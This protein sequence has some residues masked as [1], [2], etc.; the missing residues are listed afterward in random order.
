MNK[1]NII[2]NYVLKYSCRI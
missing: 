1:I 2:L